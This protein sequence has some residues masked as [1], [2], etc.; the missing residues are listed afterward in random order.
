MNINE[1]PGNSH[2]EKAARQE[3]KNAGIRPVDSNDISIDEG[4]GIKRFFVNFIRHD[5]KTIRRHIIKSLLIPRIEDFII[6]SVNDGLNMAFDRGTSGKSSTRRRKKK[7]KDEYGRTAY[8]TFYDYDDDEEEYRSSGRKNS[9]TRYQNIS[10]NSKG[11]LVRL[12]DDMRDYLDLKD[13]I[14]VGEV[15]QSLHI[16]TDNPQVWSY[17]WTDLSSVKIMRYEDKY[18]LDICDPYPI[19]RFE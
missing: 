14:P 7:K 11:R 6:D 15:Y 4:K 2:K 16:P 12:I 5:I 13:S 10:F 9:L 17:G 3:Q 18:Y 8:E 1:I 19:K